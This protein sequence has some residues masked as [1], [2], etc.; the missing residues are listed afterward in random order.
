MK[1][2]IS[3]SS[4]EILSKFGTFTIEP[5]GQIEI[6]GKGLMNTFWLTGRTLGANPLSTYA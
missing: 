1:I 2:H 6:K 4:A 5:R 3:E